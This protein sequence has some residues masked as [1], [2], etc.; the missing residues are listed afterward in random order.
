[1][2]LML[3]DLL[4]SRDGTSDTEQRQTGLSHALKALCQVAEAWQGS[5]TCTVVQN[6]FDTGI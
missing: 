3:A 5:S 1:M 6:H 2:D 4:H